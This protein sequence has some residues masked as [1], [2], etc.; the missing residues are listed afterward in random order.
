MGIKVANFASFIAQGSIYEYHWS[1]WYASCQVSG[2]YDSETEIPSSRISVIFR[3]CKG[4]SGLLS[5]LLSRFPKDKPRLK[6]YTVCAGIL[7][8]V[9]WL[10]GVTKT[11]G[12]KRSLRHVFNAWA[13]T[14]AGKWLP[15]LRPGG[16]AWKITGCLAFKRSFRFRSPVCFHR[17]SKTWIWNIADVFPLP[18]F[19]KSPGQ[20]AKS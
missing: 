20:N 17:L 9:R 14:S 2:Q 11:N 5:F 1:V 13:S 19:A 12:P 3:H 10:I 16:A 18:R 15:I 8:A 7:R 6:G 4:D